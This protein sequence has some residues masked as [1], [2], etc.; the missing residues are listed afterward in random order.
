MSDRLEALRSRFESSPFIRHLGMRFTSSPESGVVTIAIE[1]DPSKHF[2]SFGNV[3][4]GV[5]LSLADTA[6]ASALVS[7]LPAG[8]RVAT[9]SLAMQFTAPIGDE[10]I[11]AEGGVVS[12]S[13]RYGSVNVTVVGGDGRVVA[14]G[15]ATYAIRPP[16]DGSA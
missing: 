12:R 10:T 11:V 8:H 9:V 16:E 4:G 5:T 15:I 13:R 1:P 2:Q 14:H 3:H 7:A 6:G